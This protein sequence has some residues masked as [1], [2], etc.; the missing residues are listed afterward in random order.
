MSGAPNRIALTMGSTGPRLFVRSIDRVEDSIFDAVQE[1]IAAG[2]TPIGFLRS[3][4]EAWSYALDESKK[5][6][7]RELSQ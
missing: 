4:R 7:I 1:A 6:A 5:E 3:V 2:W